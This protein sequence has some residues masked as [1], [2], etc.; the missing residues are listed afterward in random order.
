MIDQIV[1]SVSFDI[2][3]VNLLQ[4]VFFENI[5]FLPLGA[6]FCFVS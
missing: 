2:G 6:L 4:P 1:I 5:T 3:M